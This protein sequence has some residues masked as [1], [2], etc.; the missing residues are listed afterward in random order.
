[1]KSTILVVE[2]N[3]D[4]QRIYHRILSGG[5][6]VF[7]AYDTKE[8]WRI[9]SKETIDLMILDIILPK[10]KDGDEFYLQ[11]VQHPEYE[12]IPVIFATV[13]DDDK[14]AKTFENIKNAAWI[15]KPFKE[16]ELLAKIEAMLKNG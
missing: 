3:K 8:A 15:T 12:S 6:N 10:G 11:I 13:I 4:L 9:L 16:Q 5:Y 2:D 7:Q 14:K 1:M